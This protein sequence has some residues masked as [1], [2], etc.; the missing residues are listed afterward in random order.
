MTLSSAIRSHVL[1]TVRVACLS[2]DLDPLPHYARLHGLSERDLPPVALT[3]AHA[4]AIPRFLE[5]FARLGARGTFFAI[6]EDLS[7]DACAQAVREAA[8]AG[9][10]IGNHT[11]RHDYALVRR[12]RS[13]I[14][15]EVQ[16]GAEAIADAVG[17]RPAGFR[18]PGYTLSAD[19]YAVL[20][21]QGYAYDSSAFPAAPYYLAKAAV[22]GA[23]ALLGRRSTAI[24]DRPRV[25]LAPRRPYRPS[26]AEP[27]RP[28]DGPVWEL[29]VA[30]APWTRVPFIGTTLVLFPRAAVAALYRTLRREPF[31][32]LELH[33]V[34][35]LDQSDGAGPALAA[36]RRDLRIPA[37]AK[38]ARLAEVF[39]WIAQDFEVVTLG[40]AAARL[41]DAAPPQ[42]PR[43]A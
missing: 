1:S 13:A 40:E 20:C 25:L 30:A 7:I 9:H 32:N 29:P 26:A 21:E 4:A 42:P 43:C 27:Y 24:L 41:Q 11:F 17:H 19:L 6:G 34:D 35:V 33:A 10:E 16:R 15:E 8:G 14:A 31:L 22:L 23:M 38:V 39:G 12:D 18:A 28:G 37:A 2:V 36:R 3:A 5:L